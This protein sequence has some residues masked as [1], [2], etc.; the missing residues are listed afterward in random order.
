MFYALILKIKEEKMKNMICHSRIQLYVGVGGKRGGDDNCPP[1]GHFTPPAMCENR[2]TH[3]QCETVQN[4]RSRFQ[5]FS[6]MWLIG[7]ISDSFNLK[8]LISRCGKWTSTTEGPFAQSLSHQIHRV[9]E[10]PN[11]KKTLDTF[12]IK[13]GLNNADQT[14]S[15][16]T[17]TFI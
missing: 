11:R 13:S 16:E 10:A 5:C 4:S 7:H 3:L 17:N 1:G 14:R 12:K 15:N 2:S 9:V 8:I 6:Q